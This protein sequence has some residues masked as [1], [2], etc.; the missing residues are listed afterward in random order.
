M[1]TLYNSADT[2]QKCVVNISENKIPAE[3]EAF[4][5]KTYMIKDQNVFETNMLGEKIK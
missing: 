1:P 3:F 5:V 4:E 2:P